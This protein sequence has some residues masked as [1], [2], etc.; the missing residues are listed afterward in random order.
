MQLVC[1]VAVELSSSDLYMQ[2]FDNIIN[3]GSS[4][5]EQKMSFPNIVLDI[6][7]SISMR[8]L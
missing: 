5:M 3:I 8:I 2:Y 7:V 4:N 6:I 1:G